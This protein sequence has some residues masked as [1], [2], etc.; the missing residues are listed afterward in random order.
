[1]TFTLDSSSLS[2]FDDASHTWIVE[3]G[4]FDVL[5]GSSSDDIRSKVSFEVK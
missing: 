5:V 3:P 4:K 2:Y 1:M